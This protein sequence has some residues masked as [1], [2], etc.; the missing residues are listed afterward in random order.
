MTIEDSAIVAENHMSVSERQTRPAEEPRERQ[1]GVNHE[2]S[3]GRTCVDFVKEE[4]GQMTVF[5]M[6]GEQRQPKQLVQRSSGKRR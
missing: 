2:V 6:K 1:E 5:G 4:A 3:S